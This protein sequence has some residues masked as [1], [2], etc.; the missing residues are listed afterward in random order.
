[1]HTLLVLHLH[2]NARAERDT[3]LAPLFFFSSLFLSFPFYLTRPPPR[4][5]A[6]RVV[7]IQDVRDSATTSG[8]Q[9]ACDNGPLRD[10]RQPALELF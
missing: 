9:W 7:C 6:D 3:V 8:K 4:L 5:S 1:M 10:R 2:T